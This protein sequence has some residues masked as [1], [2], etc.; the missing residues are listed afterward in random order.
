MKISSVQKCSAA[1][2]T[3]RF[4][5]WVVVGDGAGHI[6]VGVRVANEAAGAIRGAMNAA[7]LNIFPVRLGYWGTKFGA[8]H[9]VP[10]KVEG[11]CGSVKF[12]LIPA[13]RGTGLVASKTP[14]RVLTLAGVSD[15]Y[16]AS[17]GSTATAGNYVFAIQKAL[18]QT[19]TYLTPEFW[20]ETPH[21]ATPYE[22]FS[23]YLKDSK[24]KL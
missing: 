22:E 8:P 18:A 17:F 2:Q 3:T 1:G 10:C 14:K 7:K 13:P 23:S 15:C 4:K 19:Y 20:A 12:R 11:K 6:G 9:T 24:K 16:T 21:Q 5:A